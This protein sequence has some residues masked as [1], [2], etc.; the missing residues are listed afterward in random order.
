MERS[1]E[2]ACSHKNRYGSS[3]VQ[4][5]DD[6]QTVFVRLQIA[7][8]NRDFSSGPG[9]DIHKLGIAQ[10]LRISLLWIMQ[11]NHMGVETMIAKLIETA[12]ESVFVKQI[13]S[14]GQKVSQ[15]S[16]VS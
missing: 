7:F 16:G 15:N 14:S 10:K 8:C 6:R 12:L 5:P 4:R 2:T 11:L 9:F 3:L 13:V 1:S